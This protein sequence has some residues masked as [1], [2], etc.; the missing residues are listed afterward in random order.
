[1]TIRRA[2]LV[3]F[4]S[5]AAFVAVWAAAAVPVKAD[6]RLLRMPDIGAGH[7]A[8]V[9]AGDIWVADRDGGNA[10]RLTIH[11][12]QETHP[13]ISPD[14]RMVAFTGNYDGNPDLY[15]VSIDGGQP[16]RLTYHPENLG[17]VIRFDPK[18]GWS[19]SP[20]TSHRATDTQRGV[21]YL[22]RINSFG[23]R[24]REFS[25]DPRVGRRSVE[26]SA[27]DP[28]NLTGVLFPG[29]RVPAVR[30]RRV[31]YVDGVPEMP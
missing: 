9:Y 25:P 21:D 24:D 15:V 31:V 26:V 19:L 12:A 3:R 20:N 4:L 10:S 17:T 29:S 28:L 23:I 8:F 18:L 30:T 27:T 7:I 5:I 14:G 2:G 6:T 16:R 13:N 1:M 22:V 11:P